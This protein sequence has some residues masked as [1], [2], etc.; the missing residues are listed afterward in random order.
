M[1]QIGLKTLNGLIQLPILLFTKDGIR[2]AFFYV[3]HTHADNA[4]LRRRLARHFWRRARQAR[5]KRHTGT[6][7]RSSKCRLESTMYMQ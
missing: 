4:S 7:A 6:V 2:L 3:T 5:G 1:V